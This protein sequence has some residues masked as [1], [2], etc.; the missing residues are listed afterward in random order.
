MTTLELNNLL[1]KFLSETII[2]ARGYENG[3]ND[4]VEQR[5]IKIKTIYV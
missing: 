2:V 1:Q 3:D 4:I 5:Q